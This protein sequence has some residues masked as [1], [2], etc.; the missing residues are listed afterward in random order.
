[1]SQ[2]WN[3][4]KLQHIRRRHDN[5]DTKPRTEAAQIIEETTR[6][7]QASAA[8]RRND[9]PGNTQPSNS[10]HTHP[11]S[12]NNMPQGQNVANGG[13]QSASSSNGVV[14]PTQPEDPRYVNTFS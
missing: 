6:D 13:A 8:M 3:V 14:H 1:M 2:P 9:N 5:A 11:G 4:G 10:V 7:L 12:F